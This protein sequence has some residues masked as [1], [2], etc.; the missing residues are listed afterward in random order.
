MF[1]KFGLLF[2]MLGLPAIIYLVYVSIAENNYQKLPVFGPKEAFFITTKQK[3]ADTSYYRLLPLQKQLER[4]ENKVMVVSLFTPGDFTNNR[5]R[6]RQLARVEDVFKSNPLI[7]M[8]HVHPEVEEELA[9]YEGKPY[10]KRLTFEGQ[11]TRLPK[12]LEEALL[13]L[14]SEWLQ[15]FPATDVRELSFLVDKQLRVRGFYRTVLRKETDRLMEDIR[16]LIVEYANT[17]PK[18]RRR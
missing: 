15:T 14:Q 12:E 11:E 9:K 18:R 4:Q 1:K 5:L 6:Y 8:L 16:T 17:E 2:L 3:Y 13:T 10:I 7:W